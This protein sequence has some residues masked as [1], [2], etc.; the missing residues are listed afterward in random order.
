VRR[1][2]AGSF[3]ET[4]RLF[5]DRLRALATIDNKFNRSRRHQR[6]SFVMSGV[7]ALDSSRSERGAPLKTSTFLAAFEYRFS[8]SAFSFLNFD[9]ADEDEFGARFEF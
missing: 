8:L 2:I 5:P 1:S 3:N 9:A 6:D 4:R 7:R